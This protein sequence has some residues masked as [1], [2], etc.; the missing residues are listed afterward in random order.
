MKENLV[1]VTA[2]YTNLRKIRSNEFYLDPVDSLI[3]RFRDSEVKLVIFT[4]QPRAFHK[5]ENV[6]ILSPSLD[7]LIADV[8]DEPNWRIEFQNMIK[9]R[10]LRN[11]EEAVCPDLI[12]VWLGKAAMLAHAAKQGTRVLWQDAALVKT[13]AGRGLKLDPQPNTYQEATKKLLADYPIVLTTENNLVGNFHGVS[14]T[15]YA[16]NRGTKKYVRAGL[17]LINSEAMNVF[18][19]EFKKTWNIMALDKAGGTEE[20]VLSV[21]YWNNPKMIKTLDYWQW[22]DHLKNKVT[23]L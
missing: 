23:L 12:G 11:F 18:Y 1:L 16:K 15:P 2:V 21:L 20:N 9:H 19:Q 7:E 22:I 17:I 3:H 6:E 10:K 14:M 4:N 5:A 8:W 13:L